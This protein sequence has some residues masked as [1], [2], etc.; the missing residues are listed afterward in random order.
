LL[1]FVFEPHPVSAWYTVAWICAVLVPEALA[2]C[3]VRWE[4]AR[5]AREEPG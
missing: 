3:H 4:L 1:F 5:L 2:L